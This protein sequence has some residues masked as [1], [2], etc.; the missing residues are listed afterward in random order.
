VVVE[1]SGVK[2]T[3]FG[4]ASLP[5]CEFGSKGTKLSGVFGIG[6]YRMMRRKESDYEERISYVI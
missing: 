4:E 3:V 5:G 1:S 6:S 2:G